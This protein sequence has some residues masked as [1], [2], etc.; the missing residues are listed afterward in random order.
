[1]KI[2]VAIVFLVTVIIVSVPVSY[3]KGQ[4]ATDYESNGAD[5]FVTVD[6]SDKHLFRNNNGQFEYCLQADKL[7]LLSTPS[8]SNCHAWGTA[9]EYV[10]KAT[11]RSNAT[12]TGM[13][14]AEV[15]HTEIYLFYR[16]IR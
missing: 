14:V 12:Y 11:N 16:L 7:S 3:A 6:K 13:G 9:T 8:P 10:K 1:M 4:I 2:V 15:G 5:G